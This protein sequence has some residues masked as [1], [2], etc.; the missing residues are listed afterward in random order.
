[1]SVCI[2]VIWHVLDL[3]EELTFMKIVL[4]EG[5]LVVSVRKQ[6][7]SDGGRD[8]RPEKLRSAKNNK[9]EKV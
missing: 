9:L 7:M 2:V 6:K 5:N 1:M 8:D 4:H 3:H